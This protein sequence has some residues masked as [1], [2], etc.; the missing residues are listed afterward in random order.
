MERTL[1]GIKCK[2]S[3]TQ[4]SII[5]SWENKWLAQILK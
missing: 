1:F 5:L 3:G 2:V 4:L